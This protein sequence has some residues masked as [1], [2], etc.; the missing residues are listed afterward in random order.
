MK[1]ISLL[2]STG[3]IGKQTLEVVRE[4][5]DIFRISALVAHSQSDVLIEQAK[6]FEPHIVGIVNT[7]K[8]LEVKEALK[9]YTHIGVISGEEA[10]IAA[11]EEETCDVVLVAV[12]GVAGILPV[13]HGIKKGKQIALANKETLV[14]AGSLIMNLCKEYGVSILP[15]DSEHSAIFQC[16]EGQDKENVERLILTASGGALRDWKKEDLVRA[17]ASDCLKHPNWAMGR[18]IT[19]DS[20]TLFN[21]GLEVIEARWLFDVDYD[22]IDVVVH[23]ESIV[24]SMIQMKDGAVLAQMGYPDM[25]EPIQYALSYPKRLSMSMKP[26]SF[27]EVFSLTFTPPRWDDFPALRL[28]FEAGRLGGYAPAVYNAANEVA[29][30]FF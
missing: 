14:A 23:K 6:E 11:A 25:R 29:V 27:Q 15:V 30:E 18:K 10:L 9:E 19:I 22:S 3:S 17:R 8:Y 20:A 5:A 4:H 26:L 13:I 24:H 1:Y 12:L 7:S 2:G 21:K 28:A 16:L